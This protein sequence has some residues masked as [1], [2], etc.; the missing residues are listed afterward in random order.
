MLW[1]LQ[2]NFYSEAGYS[3]LV[4]GIKRLSL[5]FVIVK[6]V[7]FTHRLLPAEAD[8][9]S[10]RVDV[11][12]IPEAVIDASQPIIPMGSYTLAR[13]GQKRGWRPG[14]ML[15]NLDYETWALAWGPG[16]L[17]NPNARV[18]RFEDANFDDETAF[19]RPVEDS[20][21]FAGKV[22]ERG[23]W[24]G[25]KA[26]VLENCQPADALNRDTEVL[27]AV[28]VT[29]YSETRCWVVG[30]EIVTVSGYK[31]GKQVLYTAGADD[32]VLRF[33]SECI[34][35]W[36]PNVAFVLDIAQT[37]DGCRIVEV[38]CLNAAGFYA[39]DT[40]KLISA[41]EDLAW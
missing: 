17:L 31:R 8:T 11:E 38:N 16:R 40:V 7:P 28:P 18:C 37:Q 12:A 25:W 41:L 22:F 3:R 29:I 34:R 39:A 21:S 10:S 30:G 27:I 9:S 36:T 2:N 13:I 33:A 23:E 24:R 6:P 20:K 15:A 1:V 32:E 5:P 4:D 35:H 26:R 14:A 19:V